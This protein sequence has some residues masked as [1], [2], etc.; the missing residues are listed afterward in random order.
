MRLAAILVAALALTACGSHAPRTPEG[1][2]R[3]WSAALDKADDERAASFFAPGAEVVQDTGVVLG[4]HDDAVAWNEALPCGGTITRVVHQ[5]ARFV[6]VVF[7]LTDRPGHRCDAPGREAA[8]IF[9]VVDGKIVL[10]HQTAPPG[11]APSSSG[12]TV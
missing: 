11:A 1:V 3:A 6:L 4:T 12:Q 2:A 10:W 7:H 9:K 8:A 5:S